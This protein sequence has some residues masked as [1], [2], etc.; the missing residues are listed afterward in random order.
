MKKWR[1][2]IGSKISGGRVTMILTREQ[3][4]GLELPEGEDT[5]HAEGID[6]GRVLIYDE[7]E[8][9]EVQERIN[10]HLL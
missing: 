9:R 3:L 5:Q 4:K 6:F 1:T 8:A 7:A 2:T 10:R